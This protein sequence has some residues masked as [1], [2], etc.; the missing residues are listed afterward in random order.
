[1]KVK[2]T[3]FE[4]ERKS[5]MNHIGGYSNVVCARHNFPL[6]ASVSKSYKCKCGK[7]E[8]V[9]CANV[10]C[11]CCLCKKCFE[12]LNDNETH[13]INTEGVVCIDDESSSSS[14]YVS[15]FST[16]QNNLFLEEEQV[17]DHD[18]FDDFVTMTA[19]FDFDDGYINPHTVEE[20]ENNSFC[21]A[22][23]EIPSTNAGE[24]AFQVEEGTPILNGVQIPVHTLMNQCASLLVRNNHK[25]TRYINQKHL[26][27]HLCATTI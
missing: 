20:E 11:E 18:D 7:K 12:S 17:L 14:T 19:N 1:M 5:F 8:Y 23:N 6:I 16:N 9:T 26:M 13:H 4:E 25:I 15:S 2:N 24:F 3:D 21:D 22:V 27:Q 10:S